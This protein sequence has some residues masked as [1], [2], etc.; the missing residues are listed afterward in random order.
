[1][2]QV[3]NL[4]QG[5]CLEGF[6]GIEACT[7]DLVFADPPFNIG[8]DYD[9]YDDR[10]GADEYLAW[11]GKWASE[12]HRVLKPNGTFWLAIGD[13]FAAE[14]KVACQEL[15]FRCRSWV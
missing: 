5:D 8:Y 3:N 14:L 9:I 2:M 4:Y 1:M 10:K 13:D 11:C 15:G 7:A 12:I 6:A